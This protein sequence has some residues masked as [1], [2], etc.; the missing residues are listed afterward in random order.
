MENERCEVRTCQTTKADCHAELRLVR[1]PNDARLPVWIEKV[2]GKGSAWTPQDHS[3]I[4]TRHFEIHYFLANKRSN[5][6]VK[7]AVPSLSLGIKAIYP[8]HSTSGSSLGPASP[9]TLGSQ[10]MPSSIPPVS[11]ST[12]QQ[13]KPPLP[14]AETNSTKNSRSAGTNKL[15]G[16]N[17]A[18]KKGQ[19]FKPEPKIKDV[20]AFLNQNVEEDDYLNKILLRKSVS[21]LISHVEELVKKTANTS[22]EFELKSLGFILLKIQKN[23]GLSADEALV[24]FQE[25]V[26][27]SVYKSLQSL[28]KEDKKQYKALVRSFS[29]S[30]NFYSLPAYNYVRSVVHDALPHPRTIQA[31]YTT[32][33]KYMY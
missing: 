3:R 11:V 13:F 6:L 26:P 31:W 4:C 18:K 24:I 27:H 20:S 28:V 23:L 10:Y 5:R 1:F 16:K 2:K 29:L 17:V 8:V 19:R 14:L 21:G 30:L 7:V 15:K 22:K 32:I 33:D 9:L 25:Q 12:V